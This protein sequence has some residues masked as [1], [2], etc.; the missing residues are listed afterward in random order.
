MIKCDMKSNCSEI[1]YL[2]TKWL[3]IIVMLN[4]EICALLLRYNVKPN[5]KIFF[6]DIVFI[7]LPSG[8]KYYYFH[9]SPLKKKNCLADRYS[10]TRSR[11]QTN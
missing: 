7:K 2:G 1:F 9:T 10:Q 6:N 8:S 3:I 11:V 4:C 5:N